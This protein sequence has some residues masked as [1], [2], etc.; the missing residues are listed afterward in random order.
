MSLPPPPVPSLELLLT[1]LVGIV[2]NLVYSTTVINKF[3][4]DRKKEN[5]LEGTVL[6]NRG[7]S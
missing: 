2:I 6:C 5:N 1:V 4:L 3:G 7:V